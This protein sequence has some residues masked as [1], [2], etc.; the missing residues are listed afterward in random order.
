MM[1]TIIQKFSK[2][3]NFSQ[4]SFATIIK[5][6]LDGLLGICT[7]SSPHVKKLNLELNITSLIT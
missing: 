3:G 5:R 2:S 1:Q 6:N 7:R 4:F